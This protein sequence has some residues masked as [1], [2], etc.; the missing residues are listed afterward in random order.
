MEL[1]EHDAEVTEVLKEEGRQERIASQAVPTARSSTCTSGDQ[2]RLAKIE[3]DYIAQMTELRVEFGQTKQTEN[4][5]RDDRNNWL[6]SDCGV[7]QPT[8]V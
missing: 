1:L 3:A 2:E 8:R 4:R 7:Q 5:L 6:A